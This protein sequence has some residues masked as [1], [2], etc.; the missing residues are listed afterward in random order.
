MSNYRILVVEDE[1]DLAE[2]LKINL[3]A[4]GYKVTLAP[5]GAVA[6]NKL[7]TESFDMIIMNIMMPAKKAI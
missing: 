7:K 1:T 2:L 3:E 6:I 4:E 5:H